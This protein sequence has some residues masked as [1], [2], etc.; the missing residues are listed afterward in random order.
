MLRLFS[1]P[2]YVLAGELVNGTDKQTDGQTERQ[3]A[4]E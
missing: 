4:D 3:T 1:T 2:Y